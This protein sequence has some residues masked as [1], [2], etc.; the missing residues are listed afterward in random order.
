M[1]RKFLHVREFR[2]IITIVNSSYPVAIATYVH[3]IQIATDAHADSDVRSY[4][5]VIRRE[6]TRHETK[7]TRA[8]EC[9][10]IVR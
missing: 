2:R 9:L 4:T 3:Y 6:S 7:F 8:I 10:G 1:P 5:R